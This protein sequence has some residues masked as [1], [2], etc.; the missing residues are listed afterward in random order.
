MKQGI[1]E[2][3]GLAGMK[4][5]VTARTGKERGRGVFRRGDVHRRPTRVDQA[6]EIGA[7]ALL[8]DRVGRVRI[9]PIKT[10]IGEGGQRAPAENPRIPTRSG[11]TPH[12][13]ARARMM[14]SARCVS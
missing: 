7:A 5:I 2:L 13:F 3:Y 11:F 9:A 14:R 1:E 4:L 8:L 12:S 6:H 10:N